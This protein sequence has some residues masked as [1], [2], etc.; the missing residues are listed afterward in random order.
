M[1]IRGV[2]LTMLDVPAELTPEYNRWYDFDHLPEHLS[3]PDVVTATRYVAIK[4]LRE[5]PGV[6]TSELTG[7]HPPY[8]T[9]YLLGGELDFTSEEALAG[10]RD[11]DR[12]NVKQGRHWRT[13]EGRFT[14]RM[15]LE[16]AVARPSI[17]VA[18]AA[19]P[20]LPHRGVVVCVGRAPSAERRQ[21][22]VDWWDRTHLVDLFGVP[23]VLA[24]LRFAPVDEAEQDLVVH[25]LYCDVRPGTV[26]A[27]MQDELRYLGGIGRYPAHGGRYEELAVLPF[28]RIVPLEYGFDVS[29]M[30]D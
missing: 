7:G 22:A 5:T 20:H 25:V 21:E 18:E 19:V 10:W 11:M 13:G 14:R 26:M 2:L 9:L 27:S 6:Q 28:E 24:A 16:R 29:D 15:R 12:S 4:A 3:K 1:D 23:G 8:L 30:T 17:L